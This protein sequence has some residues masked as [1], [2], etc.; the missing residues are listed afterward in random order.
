M[1]ILLCVLING[2]FF[3]ASSLSH[4]AYAGTLKVCVDHVDEEDWQG[5]WY[6]GPVTVPAGAVFEYAGHIIGGKLQDPKDLAHSTT[7]G[8][9]DATPRQIKHREDEIY[10]DLTLPSSE[11]GAAVTLAPLKLTEQHPCGIVGAATLLDPQD[12]WATYPLFADPAE[13]YEIAGVI[14]YGSLHENFS[15]HGSFDLVAAVSELHASVE[16]SLINKVE[17]SPQP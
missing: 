1:R 9:S 17:I 10:K 5:A 13:F 14:K 16:S 12:G 6:Y 4:F 8:W 11:I 3:F 7:S 2:A 15:G